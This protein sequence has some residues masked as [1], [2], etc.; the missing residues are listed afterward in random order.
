MK[1]LALFTMINSK[2]GTF[3]KFILREVRF[4]FI[5]VNVFNQEQYS[6]INK[7]LLPNGAGNIFKGL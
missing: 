5:Y 3:S 2:R 6:I 7:L 4:K 1:T